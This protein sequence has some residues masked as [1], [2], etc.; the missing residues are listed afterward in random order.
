MGTL[1]EEGFKG[2]TKRVF[3]HV[4]LYVGLASIEK[5]GNQDIKYFYHY[6]KERKNKEHPR[7]ERVDEMRGEL[8][9]DN[10]SK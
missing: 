10:V 3:F 4:D 6:H 1:L 7:Q 8:L 2:L 9:V 5:Q